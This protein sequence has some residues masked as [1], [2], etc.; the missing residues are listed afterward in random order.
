MQVD[1][2]HAVDAA[3]APPA[4]VRLDLPL[5]P[6]DQLQHQRVRPLRQGAFHAADQLHE[7]GLDAEDLRLGAGRARPGRDGRRGGGELVAAL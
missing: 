1:Q 4:F 3:L 7:E 6:V 5:R 2:E